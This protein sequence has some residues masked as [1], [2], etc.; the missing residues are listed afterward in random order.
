MTAHPEVLKAIPHRPPFLFVDTIL[1]RTETTLVA[2]RTLRADE[3]F[4]QGHYP[5][6]PIM[7]GVLI[8]EATFQAAAIFLSAKFESSDSAQKTPVLVRIQEARFRQMVKPGDTLRIEVTWKESSGQFHFLKGC[9]RVGGKVA[10]T[11]EFAL[12]MIDPT[13]A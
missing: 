6:N 5:N 12:G 8:C 9:V 1:E 11:L 10:A 2:E 13:P 4:F 7:P 3:A